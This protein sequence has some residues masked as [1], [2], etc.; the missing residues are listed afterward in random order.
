MRIVI[1]QVVAE[2]LNFGAPIHVQSH[3]GQSALRIAALAHNEGVVRCLVKH[4]L[5]AGDKTDLEEYD[6]DGTPLLHTV[7]IAHDAAMSAVLLDLGTSTA[8]RDAHARTCAHVAAQV[9]CISSYCC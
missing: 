5:A 2:L 4:I 7:M 8:V 3:D 9:N 6:L 1:F